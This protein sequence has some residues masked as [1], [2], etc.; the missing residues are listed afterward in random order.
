MFALIYTDP[1][2]G[3]QEI[4]EYSKSYNKL[5]KEMYKTLKEYDFYDP[6]DLNVVNLQDTSFNDGSRIPKIDS[7]S[8][9]CKIPANPKKGI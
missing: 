9:I 1:L 2:L 5:L 4:W 3:K 7:H 6:M 8:I